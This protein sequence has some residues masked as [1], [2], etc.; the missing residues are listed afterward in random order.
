M[1]Q[2][3]ISFKSE[4]TDSRLMPNLSLKSS[5]SEEVLASNARCGEIQ[6]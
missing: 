6:V 1:N 5:E 2:N 3:S 4:I